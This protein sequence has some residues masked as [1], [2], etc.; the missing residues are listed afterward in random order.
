MDACPCG[1]AGTFGGTLP[2]DRCCGR[3]LDDPTTPA[4]DAEALMRSRYTGYVL[5][6]ADQLRASWDPAFRPRRID[7]DQG[8]TWLGLRVLD[9]VATGPDAAQVEFVARLR[10]ASGRE[11]TVHE[12]SR[13]VRRDGRWLYTDGDLLG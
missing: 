9:H 8:I 12:R 3:H 10:D 1:R 13:F 11:A 4:P 6:R 5:G 2:Y 7:L